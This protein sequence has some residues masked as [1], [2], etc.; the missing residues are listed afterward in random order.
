MF[1]KGLV[2]IHF[3]LKPYQ[4]FK[5]LG[6]GNLKKRISHLI[7]VLRTRKAIFSFLKIK[8]NMKNFHFK[9]AS[10]IFIK[11]QQDQNNRK[12]ENL[13]LFNRIDFLLF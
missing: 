5:Y 13:L 1:S 12:N 4:G 9:Y 3:T 7:L 6:L 8:I 2:V 10:V 11:I